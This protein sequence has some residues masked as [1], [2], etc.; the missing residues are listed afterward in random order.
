[1]KKVKT[2]FFPAFLPWMNKKGKP[3]SRRIGLHE[4]FKINN[5]D[6]IRQYKKGNLSALG[7]LTKSEDQKPPASRKDFGFI[8]LPMMNDL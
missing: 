2:C 8:V 4:Y 6:R 1:M 5:I 7:R 3:A